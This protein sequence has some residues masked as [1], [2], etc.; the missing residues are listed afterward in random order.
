MNCVERDD[1]RAGGRL[2]SERV[3][4]TAAG[5]HE[6]VGSLGGNGV[7]RDLGASDDGDAGELEL[8]L[9]VRLEV[10]D[11]LVRAL[12]GVG[13]VEQA[14]EHAVLLVQGDAVPAQGRDARGL[15]AGGA[16]AH[17]HD[18]LG[19]AGQ[20]RELEALGH[21]LAVGALRAGVHAA[22]LHRVA[23]QVDVEVAVHA[24]GARG[25]LVDAALAQLVDVLRVDGER[26]GHQEEVDLAVGQG[27]LEEVGGV[28]RVHVGDGAH[29]D[30]DGALELLRDVEHHAGSRSGWR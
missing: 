4:Q 21:L 2:E 27:G 3:A 11:V 28:G 15:H 19:V 8:L 20:R 24:T 23:L 14:A 30:R 12:H 25:D 16:T 10:G 18:L 17:D 9:E 6:G 1:L 13:E 22:V 29:G 26:A 7:G 5:E